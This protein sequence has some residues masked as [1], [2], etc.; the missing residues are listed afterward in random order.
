VL[1]IVL[2]TVVFVRALINPKSRAGRLLFEFADS[3]TLIVSKQ[4]AQELLEVIHRPELTAK[5]KSL[6]KVNIP[7]V[8]DLLSQAEAVKIGTPPSVAR[9]PKDNI[10]VATALEGHADYL[11]GEDK[12]LLVLG[13]SAGVPLINLQTFL[14]ILDQ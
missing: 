7:R 4:T 12:D 9:D 3:Y 8:I 13:T 6:G 11:V 1:R 5:Y 14:E 2:D 10:F